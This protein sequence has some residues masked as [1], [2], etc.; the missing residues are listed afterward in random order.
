MMFFFMLSFEILKTI[1]DRNAD[2]EVGVRTVATAY[3]LDVSAR[4]FQ[5]VAIVCIL[6]ALVPWYIGISSWRYAA[7]VLIAFAAPTLTLVILLSWEVSDHSV[8]IAVRVMR[9]LWFPSLG[10]MVLLR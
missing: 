10:A 8:R 6:C 1:A 7:A 3:G 4:I 5:G 2:S 9:W